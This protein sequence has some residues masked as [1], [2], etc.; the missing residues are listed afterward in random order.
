MPL[1]EY[2]CSKCHKTIEV[3]QKFS[4]TPLSACPECAGVLT[5]LV[6]RT[7]FQLKGGGWYATD[8]KK[9]KPGNGSSG[10]DS[11]GGGGSA[12]S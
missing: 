2:S 8:Y 3:I 7:S 12:A 4:E 9:S 1:Y 5:K 10:S 6:S 11:G